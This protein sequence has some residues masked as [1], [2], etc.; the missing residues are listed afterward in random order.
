MEKKALFC[1]K[2]SK[3]GGCIAGL[4]FHNL[5]NCISRFPEIQDHR[6]ANVENLSKHYIIRVIF[7]KSG[8][9]KFSP[10]ILKS[11]SGSASM[12][13]LMPL[14]GMKDRKKYL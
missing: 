4:S 10:A 14:E 1:D 3:K 2:Y 6:N 9:L 12:H 8:Y 13:G 7:L 5:N 11:C